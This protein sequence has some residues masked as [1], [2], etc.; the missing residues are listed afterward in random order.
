[1]TKEEAD[2]IELFNSCIE[3][4]EDLSGIGPFM[5]TIHTSSGKYTIVCEKQ[6]SADDSVSFV[7]Y[8]EGEGEKGTIQ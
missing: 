8:R 5:L 6:K 1:M 2:C 4:L 3:S 7:V